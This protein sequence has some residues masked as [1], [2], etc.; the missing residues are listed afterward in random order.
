[1]R[2]EAV[3][4]G[5]LELNSDI[6]LDVPVRRSRDW[7]YMFT[8]APGAVESN[9][10]GRAAVYHGERYLC[11]IDRGDI[12]EIKIYGVE[13]GFEPIGMSDIEKYD[14]SKVS[15]MEILPESPL[16]HIA[17]SKAQSHDDNYTLADNGKVFLYQAFRWGKVRGGVQKLGW[18]HTFEALLQ[19]NIP[20]VNR[21]SLS[22]KFNVDMLRYPLG[23]SKEVHDAL[24]AE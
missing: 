13:D 20:G 8:P 11:A 4:K 22:K 9:R 16:Y 5:L 7:T 18:R 15:Y 14:D 23:E 17:L 3:E 12:P 10:K 21:T 24:F 6:S 1:M 2:F 19:K